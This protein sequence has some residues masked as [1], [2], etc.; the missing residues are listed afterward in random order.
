MAYSPLWHHKISH[1]KGQTTH[2]TSNFTDA[3][4]VISAKEDLKNS[5]RRR[6]RAFYWRFRMNYMGFDRFYKGWLWESY[7]S[8]MGFKWEFIGFHTHLRYVKISIWGLVPE[9]QGKITTCDAF[10]LGYSSFWDRP[11]WEPQ[12]IHTLLKGLGRM[13]VWFM[14]GFIT[15][16]WP[17][18]PIGLEEGSPNSWLVFLHGKS[19]LQMD[20]LG[21]PLFRIAQTQ[22]CWRMGPFIRRMRWRSWIRDRLNLRNLV[23]WHPWHQQT[24]GIYGYEMIWRTLQ[25]MVP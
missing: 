16:S 25:N 6:S 10:F 8:Y 9:N 14:V 2:P 11:M 4:V 20:G 13:G 19:V 3:G 24:A 1:L 15:V 7:A 23:P 18:S 22:T 5:A 12:S 21:V 17:D